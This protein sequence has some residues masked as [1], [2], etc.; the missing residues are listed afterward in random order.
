MIDFDG[1]ICNGSVFDNIV[2]N[3]LHKLNQTKATV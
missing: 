3:E 1:A 2:K